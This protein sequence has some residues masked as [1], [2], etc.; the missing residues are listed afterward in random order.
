MNKFLAALLSVISV[1]IGAL[2]VYSAYTKL[3]PTVQAFEYN[4]AGNMLID[5]K[6]AAIAARFFTGIEAGLG[7]MIAAHFFGARKWVLKLAIGLILIFSIYLIWL[8]S[9]AGDQVNCGCFGGAIFMS[10]SVSLLKN[11]G[12]LAVLIVLAKYHNGFSFK[13]AGYIPLINIFCLIILP[14]AAFPVFSRYKFKFGGLYA[15]T[16]NLPTKDLQ[17][18]KHILAFLSRSCSH[19]RKTALKMH[20]MRQQNAALPFYLIIGGTDTAFYT[21]WTETKARDIPWSLLAMNQFMDYT[22]GEFPQILWINNG[23]VEANTT[24]PELDRKVI[25]DWMKQP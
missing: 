10:P 13:G 20:D 7:F 18:G 1:A 21:F 15:D 5:H 23:Y 25:E 12:I 14:F 6:T 22:G 11:I 17:H 9:Q 16:A 3:F 2:F 19:C 24:Y 8:W 4:I